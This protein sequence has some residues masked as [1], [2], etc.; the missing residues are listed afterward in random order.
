MPAL[1]A[2]SVSA[3]RTMRAERYE[4]RD[5]LLFVVSFGVVRRESKC[6]AHGGVRGE[7]AIEGQRP[8]ENELV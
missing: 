6:P 5:Y 4:R 7:S 2:V 8:R 1:T 3:A